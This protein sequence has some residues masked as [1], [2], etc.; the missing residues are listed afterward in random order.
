MPDVSQPFQDLVRSEHMINQKFQAK[1]FSFYN[2]E[3]LSHPPSD[4]KFVKLKWKKISSHA[5]E[6]GGARN[7]FSTIFGDQKAENT[8]WL[9]SSSVEKVCSF[10]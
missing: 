7:I 3:N 5:R 1:P 9:D 6:V 4:I 10:L 8:F 2:I